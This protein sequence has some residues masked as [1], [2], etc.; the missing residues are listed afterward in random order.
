MSH[1]WSQFRAKAA[2]PGLEGMSQA[3]TSS[4]PGSDPFAFY[5]SSIE[6]SSPNPT[7]GRFV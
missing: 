6:N 3:S 2:D 7:P 1:L 4:L 5:F